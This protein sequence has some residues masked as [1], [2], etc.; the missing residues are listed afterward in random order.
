MA[1]EEIETASGDL[2]R[3]ASWIIRDGVDSDHLEQYMR[4]LLNHQLIE[5][6]A[7]CRFE[8]IILA[9]CFASMCPKDVAKHL[10]ELAHELE[11]TSSNRAGPAQE[12]PQLG[13][14][15]LLLPVNANRP[16][17]ST[18]AHGRV[19]GHLSSW[20]PEAFAALSCTAISVAL[21]QPNGGDAALR[22][23]AASGC[24]FL[25]ILYATEVIRVVW[26]YRHHVARR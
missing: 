9:R 17:E 10:S 3:L 6:H 13:V 12:N 22:V 20:L 16:V 1:G 8:A 14:S 24:G 15:H 7:S 26:H 5:L 11:Q 25:S 2:R 19:R 4:G 23:T 21:L 18:P